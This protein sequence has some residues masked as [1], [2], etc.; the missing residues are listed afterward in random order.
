M[1]FI[2]TSSNLISKSW[3]GQSV[4]NWGQKLCN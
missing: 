2:V 1:Q 4:R 3:V